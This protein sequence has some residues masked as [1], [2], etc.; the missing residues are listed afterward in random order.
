MSACPVGLNNDQKVV[1]ANARS[2]DNLDLVS[3]SRVER[4]VNPDA[5]FKLFM[6]SMCLLRPAPARATSVAASATR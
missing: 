1:F 4:I 2:A 5:T 6:G 3:Y